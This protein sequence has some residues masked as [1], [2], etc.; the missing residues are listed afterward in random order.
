MDLS[1][2][3]LNYKQKGLIKQSLKNLLALDLP[4]AYEIIVVDN[5]SRDGLAELVSLEFLSVK[6]VQSEKNLGFA[7]GNNLGVARARGRYIMILNPDVI[8]LNDTI[9]KMY[10][11]M[12]EH[13]Q[14]GIV[15]PKIHNADGSLQ[16]SC[17]RFPDWHLPF[18]RRTFLS[19]TKKG[20]AW[21]N[22]YLMTD[23][24]HNQSRTVEFLY[25]ACLMVRRSFLN[26]QPLFDERYFMYMEDLDLCR[27][28]WEKGYEVW[29]LAGAQVTHFHNRQSAES[30]FF[31]ALFSK[32][33]RM[34][35]LS[36]LKYFC[37]F[38]GKKLPMVK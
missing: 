19:K 6:L 32:T 5:N 21:I 35:L 37:K 13:S 24:D 15:G 22:H 1:I 3:L 9:A 30:N 8:I 7:G 36:W 27:T 26:N 16:Y 38:K 20:R 11:F 34:H 14:A 18:Y 4:M 29:Y 31:L 2:I 23:W 25:G 12:E 17:S 33:A 10:H 28:F